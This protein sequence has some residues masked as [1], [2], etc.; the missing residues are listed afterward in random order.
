MQKQPATQSQIAASKVLLNC[1]LGTVT[2]SA[3]AVPSA[4]NPHLSSLLLVKSYSLG[5]SLNVT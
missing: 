1:N 2:A 5:L 3:R 4:W